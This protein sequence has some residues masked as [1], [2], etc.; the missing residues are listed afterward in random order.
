MKE[1]YELWCKSRDWDLGPCIK[2]KDGRETHFESIFSKIR[3]KKFGKMTG[4]IVKC[5]SP[6]HAA[7]FLSEVQTQYIS[8]N[9]GHMIF[10]G[11]RDSEWGL[12]T[13]IDRIKEDKDAYKR[14]LVEQILFATIMANL[15]TDLICVSKNLNFQLELPLEAYLPIPQHHGI[16]TPYLDFTA[17]PAVATYFAT[18][19]SRDHGSASIYGY[20]LPQTDS[21][22][23]KINMRFV[24]P[25]IERPYI[26]K[27]I[28]SD[29]TFSGD[30][31]Q[32]LP[33][34]LEVQFPN[35]SDNSNFEVIQDGTVDML[36]KEDD[37]MLALKDLT[38][39]ATT[40]FLQKHHGKTFTAEMLQNYAASYCKENQ[41]SLRSIYK[42]ELK[43]PLK[44]AMRYVELFD[45]MMFWL[46]FFPG[47]KG[48]G[49]NLSTLDVVTRSNPNLV[50][51]VISI[52]RWLHANGLDE[53]EMKNQFSEELISSLHRNGCQY[54]DHANLNSFLLGSSD[55]KF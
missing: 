35:S 45:D 23:K 27:G 32:I 14:G 24:P 37:A 5:T 28:F 53:Y 18:R 39:K 40:K 20:Y 43:N 22:N 8:T 49:I 34:E 46:C 10:R 31:K 55:R 3:T 29:S 30:Y 42:L 15:T 44:F 6:W 9:Q 21:S 16:P 13:T 26:Q 17:D 11:Q 2:P 1:D 33:P 52:Y 48:I 41:D 25:F 38:A 12:I 47:R 4:S 50:N 36:P 19:N 51:L 54:T 7:I